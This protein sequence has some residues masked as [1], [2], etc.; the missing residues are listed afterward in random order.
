MT[1]ILEDDCRT[2]SPR[3]RFCLGEYNACDDVLLISFSNFYGC[4]D[5]LEEDCWN[6]HYSGFAETYCLKNNQSAIYF[7][8][9]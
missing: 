5:T 8:S 7:V 4:N 9:L 3:Q 2:Y 6:G 1:L